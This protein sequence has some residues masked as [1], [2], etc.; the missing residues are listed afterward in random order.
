MVRAISDGRYHGIRCFVH[1]LNLV[2]ITALKKYEEATEV[3]TITKIICIHLPLR[4]EFQLN[5]EVRFG[6]ME[7][8]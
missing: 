8:I 1:T 5:S 3:S 6:S 4:C 2:V 7:K